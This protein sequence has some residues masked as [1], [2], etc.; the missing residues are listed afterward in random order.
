MD[1]GRL[2]C[3]DCARLLFHLMRTRGEVVLSVTTACA[4]CDFLDEWPSVLCDGEAFDQVQRSL[5]RGPVHF[6]DLPTWEFPS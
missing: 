3:A 1:H 4:Y 2:V 5:A 6:W